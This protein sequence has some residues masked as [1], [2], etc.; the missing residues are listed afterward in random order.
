MTSEDAS[1]RASACGE[2]VT[3]LY[4]RGT[5]TQ[6]SELESWNLHAAPTV[7]QPEAIEAGLRCAQADKSLLEQQR[8]TNNPAHCTRQDSRDREH[9]HSQPSHL[10]V[11]RQSDRWPIQPFGEKHVCCGCQRPVPESTSKHQQT[12]PSQQQ[13]GTTSIAAAPLSH[14]ISA[15]CHGSN[16]S[17]QYNEGLRSS[18]VNASPPHLTPN[19]T[20]RLHSSADRALD[21]PAYHLVDT[22]QSAHKCTHPSSSAGP[23]GP[24]QKQMHWHKHGCLDGNRHITGRASEVQHTSLSMD[25]A[26][27]KVLALGLPETFMPVL[28]G[29]QSLAACGEWPEECSTDGAGDVL[30]QALSVRDQETVALVA[31]GMNRGWA[32]AAKNSR[33]ERHLLLLLLG[34]LAI[35]TPL[36]YSP[37]TPCSMPSD[38][39]TACY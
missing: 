28:V 10:A 14:P 2:C 38:W 36:S 33:P 17:Q 15:C 21:Q 22:G 27:E 13:Q 3:P 20:L 16:H 25:G 18:P 19:P 37:S 34:V 32:A 30:L 6:G 29:L 1:C 39:C 23:Q 12:V 8:R 24:A 9:V 5:S 26:A 11:L 31:L 35:H 7:Q 4:N